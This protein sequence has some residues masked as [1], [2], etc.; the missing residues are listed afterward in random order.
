MEQIYKDEA[1]V[2]YRLRFS[3]QTEL[4]ISLRSLCKHLMRFGEVGDGVVYTCPSC[5]KLSVTI[6]KNKFIF[7]ITLPLNKEELCEA[8]AGTVVL[9]YVMGVSL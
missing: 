3:E 5:S 2:V 4:G 9:L 7:D 6:N 8:C 1:T